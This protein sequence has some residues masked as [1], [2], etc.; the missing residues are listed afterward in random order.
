VSRTWAAEQL[1]ADWSDPRDRLRLLVG[2]N[3][4]ATKD[5]GA[6]VCACFNVGLNQIV[7]AVGAQSCATVDAVGA[8][9]GAGTNCGSC[10]IEIKRIIDETR[11][12]KAS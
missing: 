4:G 7:E 11:L 6:I 9:L 10:R 2:R 12:Q 1:K 3:A 8:A 5:P